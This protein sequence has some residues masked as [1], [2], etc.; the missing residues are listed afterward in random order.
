MYKEGKKT[1]PLVSQP[2]MGLTCVATAKAGVKWKGNSRAVDGGPAI[3]PSSSFSPQGL[4]A[5]CWA[6]AS[7]AFTWVCLAALWAA[8]AVTAIAFH[9]ELTGAWKRGKKKKKSKKDNPNILVHLPAICWQA[10]GLSRER[11]TVALRV[12]R[13]QTSLG[14]PAGTGSPALL[15]EFDLYM[16]FQF[17][18]GFSK[19]AKAEVESQNSQDDILSSDQEAKM[20]SA[21]R[22]AELHQSRKPLLLK[23]KAALRQNP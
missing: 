19:H 14:I 12:A 10:S 23:R 18:R 5:T 11:Y 9:W 8:Y 6:L 3:P 20:T 15:H 16:S 2:Q 7:L 22:A 4:S 17:E 1:D 13:P 21:P